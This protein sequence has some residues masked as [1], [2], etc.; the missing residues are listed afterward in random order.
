MRRASGRG[1]PAAGRVAAGRVWRAASRAHMLLVAAISS[2]SS[3]APRNRIGIINTSIASVSGQAFCDP[4][5]IWVVGWRAGVAN[6]SRIA[7]A[8][9]SPGSKH[10]SAMQKGWHMVSAWYQI[11]VGR[12]LAVAHISSCTCSAEDSKSARRV[13]ASSSQPRGR[14]QIVTWLQAFLSQTQWQH[15]AAIVSTSNDAT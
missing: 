7:N 1:R 12:I 3:R 11:S 9:S 5:D 2:V 6:Q 4:C 13:R 14:R 15:Q 10:C 8:K